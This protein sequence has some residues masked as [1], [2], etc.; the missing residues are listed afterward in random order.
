MIRE[1]YVWDGEKMVPKSDDFA[2][3]PRIHVIGDTLPQALKHPAT[4]L[5]TDSKSRFRRETRAAGC[6]ELG[7]DAPTTPKRPE[8]QM[9]DSRATIAR[10]Y[11]SMR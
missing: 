7:T 4:G 2:L 10:V 9:E 6:V 3:S 5:V 1:T 11:E 8:I